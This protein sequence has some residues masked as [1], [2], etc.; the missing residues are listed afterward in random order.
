MVEVND[1]E[2]IDFVSITS[3]QNLSRKMSWRIYG[4]RKTQIRLGSP[5]TIDSIA[6]DP[7]QMVFVLIT[8]ILFLLTDSPQ[9]LKLEKIDGTLIILFYGSPSSPQLQ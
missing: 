5:T 2:F 9:K 4:E 3:C 6:Q 7:E 8:I 1:K